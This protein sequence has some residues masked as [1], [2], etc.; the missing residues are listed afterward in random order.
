MDKMIEN[1]ELKILGE[2]IKPGESKTIDFNIAKLYTTTNVEIPI[3]I[4]LSTKPGTLVLLTGCI[5]G[6]ELNRVEII[7]NCISR[8]ITIPKICTIICIP[9]VNIFGFLNCPREFP[10]GRDL[11]RCFP[12]IRRGS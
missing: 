10:D 8:K 5:H 2:V 3:I 12:G 4:N 11:N 1:N 9:I 7:R 6:D